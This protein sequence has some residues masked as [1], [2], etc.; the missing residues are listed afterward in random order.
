MLPSIFGENI[1]DDW[2]GFP[3]RAMEDMEKHFWGRGAG[4]MKTDVRELRGAYEIDMDLPGFKKEEI[5]LQLDNGCL[6][7]RAEKHAGDSG[8]D[9]GKML[10]RERCTETMQRS[11]YIGDVGRENVKARFSDGV[12]TL[13]FPKKEQKKLPEQ[14]NIMIES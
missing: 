9:R 12:L 11:F 3:F 13:L 2:T 1:F 10:R 7:V 14:K 8:E 6:T 4:F 5:S